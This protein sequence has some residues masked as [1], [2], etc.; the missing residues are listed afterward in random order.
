L[1]RD[2]NGKN[3]DVRSTIM[4]PLSI[5]VLAVILLFLSAAEVRAQSAQ[6]PA[7]APELL[8]TEELDQL[9]ALGRALS[10]WALLNPFGIPAARIETVGL[11][12]E[13]LLNRRNPEAAE[14]R[15]VQLINIG[16]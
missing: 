12:E 4:T 6:P 13:Q 15:R 5:R 9:V 11:G 2:G 14:N 8:K 10:R 3:I 1:K 7:S 16:Q